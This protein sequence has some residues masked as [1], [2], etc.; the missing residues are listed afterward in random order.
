LVLC[1]CQELRREVTTDIAVERDIVRDPKAVENREQ[2]ERVFGRL[3][4]RVGLFN[5]QMCLFR[6]RLRFGRG[7]SFNMDEWRYECDLKFDLLATQRGCCGQGSNLVET[8][9]ELSY[10]FD[11][12]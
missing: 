6:S 1:E 2:Q 4:Q 8:M 11:Q 5:Q 9:G 3:S 12:R 7:I 10:G